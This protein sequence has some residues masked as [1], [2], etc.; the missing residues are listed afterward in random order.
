M[1]FSKIESERLLI[2]RLTVADARELSSYRSDPVV[3]KFQSWTEYSYQR[4][5]ELVNGM[6]NSDPETRGSWFQ[7]GVELKATHQLIGDIGVLNTDEASKSWVGFTFDRGHWGQGFAFEA[8]STV[9]SFYSALS[10]RDFWAST[11]PNNDPSIRLLKKLGF[12]LVESNPDDFIFTKSL[13]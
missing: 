7:F 11:D 2:R 1:A 10:I 6:V 8:V 3:A 5:T 13:Y 4:A 9:L 12:A